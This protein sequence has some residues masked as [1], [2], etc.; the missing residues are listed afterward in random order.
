MLQCI[1]GAINKYNIEDAIIYCNETG[2]IKRLKYKDV[3]VISNVFFANLK[4]LS[5]DSSC[6][7]LLMDHNVLIPSLIISLQQLNCSFLFLDAVQSETSWLIGTIGIKYIIAYNIKCNIPGTKFLFSIVVDLEKSCDV[8]LSDSKAF[9]HKN[10]NYIVHTSGTTG[11]QKVV[12]VENKCIK[13]NINCL[14]NRLQVTNADTIYFGTTLTFDPSMIELYLALTTGAKLFIVSKVV[15]KNPALLYKILFYTKAVDITFL[16]MCPSTLLLW[17]INDIE[18]MLQYSSLR[19]LLVGGEDFPI[20]L[21][22]MRRS[23]LLKV[24]NIYGITELSCW[25]FL[26][27]LNEGEEINLGNIL[28]DTVFEIK[29]ENCKSVNEGE[30]ELFVGSFERICYLDNERSDT[31]DKPV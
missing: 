19:V 28:D 13:S 7:G 17:R 5:E 31:I 6:F 8:Y 12:R 20:I 10:I 1:Y 21:Q 30:G 23:K 25:S 2:N 22:K 3:S 16:Q 18:N 24:Y 27:E 29:G 11:M 4:Y 14:R 9:I 26:A 15:K